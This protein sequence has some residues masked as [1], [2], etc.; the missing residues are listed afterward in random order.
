MKSLE[1][2]KKKIAENLSEMDGCIKISK[3]PEWNY[4]KK[5]NAE[6]RYKKLS[7]ENE[8]LR[9]IDMYLEHNPSEKSLHETRSKF[10]R[11]IKSKMDQYAYWFN[12]AKP[13]EVEP[14]KARAYFNK[15]NG[16]THL[17]RQIKTLNLILE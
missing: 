14:K 1:E 17:R 13:D 7:R 9:K 10:Q 3:N 4:A 2:V 15:E 12:N 6:R 8:L 16:L 5:L 11:I